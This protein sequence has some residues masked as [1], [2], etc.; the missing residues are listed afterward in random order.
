MSIQTQQ[1]ESTGVQSAES[2]QPLWKNE[3]FEL[4]SNER[5]HYASRYIEQSNG[6]VEVGTLP[7]HVVAW[8]SGEETVKIFAGQRKFVCTLLQQLHPREVSQEGESEFDRR[9][10][11]VRLLLQAEDIDVCLE[12]AGK[13]DILWSEYY[14]GLSAGNLAL[15]VAFVTTIC[16]IEA[17]PIAGLAAFCITAFLV[18]SLAYTCNSRSEVRLGGG[19]RSPEV[20]G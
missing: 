18:S 16:P 9:A 19:D 20:R 2:P 17:F 6:P 12:V 3:V 11:T 1:Q 7:Q 13:Y 5:R 8:E 4:L 14:L 10:R 15:A